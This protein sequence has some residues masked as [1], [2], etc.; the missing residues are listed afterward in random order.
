M[1]QARGVGVLSIVDHDCIDGTP[2][3]L[4]AAD[5]KGIEV[6]SGVELSCEFHGRDLHVLGYGFDP[7][8]GVLREKLSRFRETRHRRGLKIIENLRKMGVDIEAQEVLAKSP[9][10]SLGRPHIAEVL[11]EKGIV[12][13]YAEAFARY[14]GED[15]PAYVKKHKLAPAEAISYIRAAGGLA[16][17]AHPGS[18]LEERERLEELVAMGFD[19][20]EIIHPHHSSDQV[21]ELKEI[22][23]KNG[24]LMSGGTDHHGFRGRDVPVGEL[25]VPWELWEEMKERL[26]H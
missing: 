24:L 7:E 17:L 20:I 12:A 5:G 25:D 2:E 13:N 15:C 10:G 6:V 11:V 16:F 22:A 3:A 19:G 4:A 8:G 14:L 23:L 26:G 18:Y 9:D 1:A 21:A